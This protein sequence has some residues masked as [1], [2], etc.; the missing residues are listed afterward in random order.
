VVP[1][2]RTSFPPLLATSP[3][4]AAAQGALAHA[5]Q[6]EDREAV[7]DGENRFKAPILI[8]VTRAECLPVP[9]PTW[10]ETEIPDTRVTPVASEAAQ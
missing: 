10:N 9:E 8:E 3:R 2:N 4:P 6:R 7:R 5:P 1:G